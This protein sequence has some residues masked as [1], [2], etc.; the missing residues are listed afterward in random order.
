M[1]SLNK[2][3]GGMRRHSVDSP[4]LPL[5]RGDTLRKNKNSLTPLRTTGERNLEFFAA[6][7]ADENMTNNEEQLK[8]AVKRYLEK[9][10]KSKSANI[11][12]AAV[13]AQTV[14]SN[15][16]EL[17]QMI[18]EIYDKNQSFNDHIDQIKKTI[19]YL[20]PRSQQKK[21]INKL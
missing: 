21:H 18:N 3:K 12:N 1:Q 4:L 7:N 14:D 5:G 11:C 6:A 17:I 19:G 15:M 20:T 9:E 13:V 10:L 8:A 16:D 2:L